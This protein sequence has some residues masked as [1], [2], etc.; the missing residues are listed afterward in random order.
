MRAGGFLKAWITMA[1]NSGLAP[2]RKA[3]ET[4]RLHWKGILRWFC[5]GLNNGIIEGLNSLPQAAKR[6]A[7]GYRK[8]ATSRLVASLIAGKL[9]L[10][11]SR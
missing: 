10:G 5:S 6:K 1:L 7:R 4:I 9:D 2:M 11:I 8:H 3:A